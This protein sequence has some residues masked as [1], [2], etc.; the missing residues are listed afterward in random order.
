MKR[1]DAL[2][3]E[4][5]ERLMALTGATLDRQLDAQLQQSVERLSVALE[6]PI[7]LVSLM[8]KRTQFFRAHVGLP[9][10]LALAQATDRD[11]S[12]CQ[13]VVRD[14]ETLEV[15]NPRFELSDE[16]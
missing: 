13:L 4:G 7:V 1:I 2:A 15:T 12:F 6:A 3:D 5:P 11:V 14:R 9:P 8:L 16:I 10:D